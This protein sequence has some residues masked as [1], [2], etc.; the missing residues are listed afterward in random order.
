MLN[1]YKDL[2]DELRNGDFGRMY[3]TVYNFADDDGW[4]KEI[5]SLRKSRYD[6]D[7]FEMHKFALSEDDVNGLKMNDSTVVDKFNGFKR[8]VENDMQNMPN[9]AIFIIKD[10]GGVFAVKP[11]ECSVSQLKMC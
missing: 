11:K 10:V 8:H 9:I 3:F 5:S 1:D 2:V 6:F 7:D 4:V